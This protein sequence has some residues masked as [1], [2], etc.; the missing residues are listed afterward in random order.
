MELIEKIMSGHILQEGEA[1]T[2]LYN[3]CFGTYNDHQIS[4]CLGVYK[5]RQPSFEEFKG[6]RTSILENAKLLKLHFDCMDVCGTGG[7]GKNTFNISTLSAFVLAASGVKIAKHGNFAS[8]SISGSSDILKYFG[9]QF[10]TDED[11]I[12]QEIDKYNLSFIH[13][14]LFH[15]SLKEIGNIRRNLKVSTLFNLLGPIVNPSMPKYRYV[16]VNNRSTA[17]L[18]NY[19]LQASNENFL[20]VHSIDGYDEISLT[21]DFIIKSPSGDFIYSPADFSLSLNEQIDLTAGNSI[22]SAAKIFLNVL[23]NKSTPQQLNAVLINCAFA[24]HLST[25]KTVEECFEICKESIISMK[26]YE[27]FKLI[28]K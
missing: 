2:L 1:K 22:E 16:G 3:L 25:E 4:L 19:L 8:S 20:I 27:I 23:Q 24:M 12:N 15:P 7:D 11:I 10:K 17:R 14:P 18:Y 28:I 26:A 6:F 21:N 13:A 5:Y 9:Y